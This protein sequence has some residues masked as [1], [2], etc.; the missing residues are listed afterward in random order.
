MEM[1]Q[2]KYELKKI[3]SELDDKI[4]IS[5]EFIIENKQLLRFNIVT[6]EFEPISI[7]DL[8][9]LEKTEIMVNIKNIK[10]S[11]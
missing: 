6:K 1:I 10:D 5:S 8:T 11:K 4:E 9:F 3:I 7:D 2:V